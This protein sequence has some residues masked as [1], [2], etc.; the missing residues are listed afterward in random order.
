MASSVIESPA[1]AVTERRISW[2]TLL[3]GLAAGLSVALLRDRLWGAGLGIGAALAW[4]NFR[5]LRR[6]LDTLVLASTA[7]TGKEKPVVPFLS[8]FGMLFRYG[9]IALAVYVIFIYLRVP[10]VSMVVGLCALGAATVV[11]TV[12]EIL[13]PVG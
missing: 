11:A 2:L 3:I 9:L 6:G 7:Q 4:L 12:Y 8:Y 13:R 5:W 10:L 1:G